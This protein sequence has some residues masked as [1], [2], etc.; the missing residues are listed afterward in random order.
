MQLLGQKALEKSDRRR[1]PTKLPGAHRVRP[2]MDAKLSQYLE[3]S[4]AA[5]SSFTLG[6]NSNEGYHGI[7]IAVLAYDVVSLD[8]PDERGR[9]WRRRTYLGTA[10]GTVVGVDCH[11]ASGESLL[12]LL[13]L[14]PAL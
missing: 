2:Y 9:I 13:E 5:F 14:L 12:L 4:V 6:P 10:A 1:Q 11:A 3:S 8:E 7:F